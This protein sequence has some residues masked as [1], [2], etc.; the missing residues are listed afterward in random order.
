MRWPDGSRV[1]IG[2]LASEA[3]N[4]REIYEIFEAYGPVDEVILHESF[5][6]VQFRDAA[7]AQTAI[8]KERGRLIGE[9]KIG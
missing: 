7:T 1:F 8:E 2:N 9:R 4:K 6:F 3:T 5:G